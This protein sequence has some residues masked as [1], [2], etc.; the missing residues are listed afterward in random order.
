MVQLTHS[1]IYL[2]G[3]IR[4]D[5]AGEWLRDRLGRLVRD[6]PEPAPP[7]LDEEQ[8]VRMLGMEELDDPYQSLYAY[9]QQGRLRACRIGKRLLYPLEEVLR[10][11]RRQTEGA[12]P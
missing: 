2:P 8:V 11:I 1:T 7:L 12:R 6:A 4:V 3:R 5:D 9:R 10:F